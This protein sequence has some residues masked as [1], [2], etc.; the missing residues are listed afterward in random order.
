MGESYYYQWERA[1]T[2]GI[3]IGS[4]VSKWSPGHVAR[5][6]D[7]RPDDWVL[8]IGCAEGLISMELKVSPARVERAKREAAKRGIKTISFEMGSVTD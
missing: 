8:D 1:T 5:I 4:D 2:I 6:I 7:L 3:L